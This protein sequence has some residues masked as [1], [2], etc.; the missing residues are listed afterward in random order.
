MRVDRDAALGRRRR[1]SSPIWTG[2]LSPWLAVTV[3]RE[4]VFQIA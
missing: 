2:G 3:S 1:L 4:K